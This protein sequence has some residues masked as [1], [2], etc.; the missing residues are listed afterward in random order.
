MQGNPRSP[1]QPPLHDPP[2]TPPHLLPDGVEPSPRPRYHDPSYILARA[3]N[4]QL[5]AERTSGERQNE[6][7]CAHLERFSGCLSK[8][9]LPIRHVRPTT[10]ICATDLEHPDTMPGRPPEFDYGAAAAPIQSPSSR[11]SLVT[12]HPFLTLVCAIAGFVTTSSRGR[13]QHVGL[14]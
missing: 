13:M 7:T 14:G 8:T 11:R 5:L 6:A 10:P 3:I 2:R 9:V 1:S 12:L 4:R